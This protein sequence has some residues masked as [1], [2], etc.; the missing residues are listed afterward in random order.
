MT[1]L[2]TWKGTYFGYL[3]DDLII[4]HRGTC[5]GRLSGEEIYDER[6]RYIGELRNGNRL[7]THKGKRSRTG[8]PAPNI[9]YGARVRYTN[10]VGYV[11]YAGFEDF[12]LPDS[13]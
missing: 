3:S 9:R 1:N 6:G 12:P 11:M 7:I 8:S 10:Y 5:A 13:F 2:W 4:T